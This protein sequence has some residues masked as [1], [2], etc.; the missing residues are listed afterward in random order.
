[1]P[2][3]APCMYVCNKAALKNVPPQKRRKKDALAVISLPKTLAVYKDQRCLGGD[4]STKDHQFKE[5]MQVHLS[6]HSVSV[7][8]NAIK[9]I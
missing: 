3:G 2:S 5:T 9:N 8:L 7:S 1:M 4:L 6:L